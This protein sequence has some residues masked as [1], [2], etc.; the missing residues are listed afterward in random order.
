MEIAR[1]MINEKRRHQ[2]PQDRVSARRRGQ[3]E[4]RDQRGRAP[5]HPGRRQDH[6]RLRSP[7]HFAIAVS[8]TAE[9]ARRAALGDGRRRRHHHASAGSNTRSRSARLHSRYGRAAVDFPRD[10]SP[11]SSANR[12]R[13]CASRCFGKTAPSAIRSA[14]VCAPIAKDLRPHDGLRRRLR[15]VRHGHDA[16]RAEIE[17]RQAGRPDCHIVPERCG[18]VPAESQRA[19]F[20][21]AGHD[22]RQRGLFRAGAEATRS[23]TR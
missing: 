4:R 8:Q 12:S 19:E 23:A 10:V 1:D 21:C 17:R 3:P 16:D 7:R 18:A 22:G 14:T 5:D 15:S 20:R 11:R 9:R 13:T 2:R 6:H